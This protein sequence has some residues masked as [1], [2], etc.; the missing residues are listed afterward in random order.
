MLS[1]TIAPYGQVF[2]AVRVVIRSG[3]SAI[4]DLV[5]RAGAKV[6]EAADADS[7]QS[8][9]L[10]AGVAASRPV[11]AL[12]IGLGDMPYVAETTLRSL[13]SAISRHPECIVRPRHDGRA[14]NPVAFPAPKFDAL[15]QV[16]A[17]MGAREIIAASGSVVYV[18]VNDPGVLVDIDTP[19]NEPPTWSP[20][21]V[22]CGRIRRS[23]DPRDRPD[24]RRGRA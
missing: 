9:S 5:T 6:V 18:D 10:A 16:R 19:I 12:V 24:A 8:R 11:D 22:C 21:P 4:S 17:D 3:E 23:C 7:G 13:R 20:S 1:R 15:T 2:D 14:G